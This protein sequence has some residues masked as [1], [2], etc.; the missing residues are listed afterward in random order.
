[1]VDDCTAEAAMRIVCH[2]LQQDWLL[3][4]A[5]GIKGLQE[6]TLTVRLSDLVYACCV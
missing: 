6:R 5:P 3:V 1:M 4:A 2:M